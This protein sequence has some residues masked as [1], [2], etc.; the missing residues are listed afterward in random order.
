METEQRKIIKV[1]NKDRSKGII[2][3]HILAVIHI[4]DQNRQKWYTRQNINDEIK[5]QDLRKKYNLTPT[6]PINA[7]HLH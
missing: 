2:D 4:L 6:A 5:K 1:Y 7:Q 3:K